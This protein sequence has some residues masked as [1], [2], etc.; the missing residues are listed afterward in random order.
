MDKETLTPRTEQQSFTQRVLPD[1]VLISCSLIAGRLLVDEEH[2]VLGVCTIFAGLVLRD[3]F[4]FVLSS[5][6]VK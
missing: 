2:I 5:T 6:S 1:S 3:F 4:K